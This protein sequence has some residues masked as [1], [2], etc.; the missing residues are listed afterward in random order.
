MLEVVAESGAPARVGDELVQVDGQPTDAMPFA[1]LI[2]TMTASQ[3]AR[4]SVVVNRDGARVALDVELV[5]V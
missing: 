1:T 5:A 4:R 3:P 2:A